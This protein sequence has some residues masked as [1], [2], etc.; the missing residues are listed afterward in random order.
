MIKNRLEEETLTVANALY[1]VRNVPHGDHETVLGQRKFA[2][3]G[4]ITLSADNGRA[5]WLDAELPPIPPA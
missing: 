2:G 4:C 1:D 5:L 3:Q